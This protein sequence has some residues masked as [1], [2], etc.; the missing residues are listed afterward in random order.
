MIWRSG[1]M[2][3][4]V[5]LSAFALPASAVLYAEVGIAP[6]AASVEVVPDQTYTYS[7]SYE[8]SY[9]ERHSYTVETPQYYT[10]RRVYVEPF[11]DN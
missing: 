8:P 10:E 4:A 9:V 6:P 2:L 11:D 7:Y 3:A 1:L 5:A